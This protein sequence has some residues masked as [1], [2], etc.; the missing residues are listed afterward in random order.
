M[1]IRQSYAG[2]EGMGPPGRALSEILC[3]PTGIHGIW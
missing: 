1:V 3:F 2:L